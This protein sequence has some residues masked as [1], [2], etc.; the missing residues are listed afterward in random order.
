MKSSLRGRLTQAYRVAAIVAIA[1]IIRAQH[2]WIRS[3]EQVPDVALAQLV[4]WLPDAFKI[5]KKSQ[6][7]GTRLI[8]NESG[9]RIGF[10]SI[11][12]PKSDWIVGYSGPTTT[13][14]VFDDNSVCLAAEILKSGDTEDHLQEVLDDPDFLAFYRGKTWDEIATLREIDAVSGAT[15]TSYAIHEGIVNRLS[16]EGPN[17]R[18]PDPVTLEE[19]RRFFDD[20]ESIEAIQKQ[21]TVFAVKNADGK[22]IGYAL[23]TAHLANRIVGYQGPID[24]LI[25]LEADRETIRGV[26]LRKSYDNARYIE[27]VIFEKFF[28][29]KFEG[30]TVT[31]FL[32]KDY[33][34][35]EIDGVSG[36]TMTSL[37]LAD[38]VALALQEESNSSL[39]ETTAW[40]IV[41]FEARDVGLLVLVIA[42]CLMAFTELRN[43]KPLR[44]TYLILLVGYVGLIS[45]DLVAQAV[46]LGWA[47]NGIAWVIS[48]GLVLLVAAAFLLPVATGRQ[49]YCNHTCPHGAAQTLIM[50]WSPK[51]WR[52]RISPKTD[53]AL[54]WIPGLLLAF[55][56]IAT[57]LNL[58][59]D[60]AALEPFDAYIWHAAGWASITLLIISLLAAPF[61]PMGYCRFGCPTGRLLELVGFK[62]K[63][64]TFG[65]REWLIGILLAVAISLF[66]FRDQFV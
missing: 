31:S 24:V 36:A 61:V 26:K 59:F 12:S 34:E 56:V 32:G 8:L 42:S 39:T 43:L 51:R 28:F 35:H 66:L 16:G 49:V 13:L 23:N 4:K 10:Y 55:I 29:R 21:P 5:D 3:Q 11:T 33:T 20:A 25:T 62:R 18:F 64:D 44:I 2:D 47:K 6:G 46:V 48:P 27:D 40:D 50:R 60:F 19:V 14:L 30:R 22:K 41:R 37:A 53:R 38:A 15:L 63:A 45:G 54:R 1:W 9:D 52:I 57:M 58:G 17:L 65:R 7:D